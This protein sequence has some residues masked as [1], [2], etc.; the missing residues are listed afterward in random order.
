M[1]NSSSNSIN[2]NYDYYFTPNEKLQV[3]KTLIGDHSA[4]GGD[5][6]TGTDGALAFWPARKTKLLFHNKKKS[7]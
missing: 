1:H 6:Q 2:S 4:G 5:E 3:I 7:Y